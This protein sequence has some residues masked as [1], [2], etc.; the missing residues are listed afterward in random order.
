ML[1]L[2]FQLFLPGR[3]WPR[4]G[5]S[6]TL[7]DLGSSSFSAPWHSWHPQQNS[8]TSVFLTT[9]LYLN[10]F[11]ET[12]LG[13][14]LSSVPGT[15]NLNLNPNVLSRSSSGNARKDN[16]LRAIFS[17]L[18]VSEENTLKP[19]IGGHRNSQTELISCSR[20]VCCLPLFESCCPWRRCWQQ[21]EI[22]CSANGLRRGGKD[23]RSPV[24]YPILSGA[25]GD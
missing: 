14:S 17:L 16:W 24:A 23:S 10:H 13:I 6:A 20:H 4:F 8:D 21:E 25:K 3:A 5:R 11:P 2:F 12:S 22:W 9:H 19:P 18:L 1:G 15:H 7:S